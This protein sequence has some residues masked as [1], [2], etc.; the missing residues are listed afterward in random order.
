MF[1]L[2]PAELIG[3]EFL[4]S[5]VASAEHLNEA[6]PQDRDASLDVMPTDQLLRL[7]ES[8]AYDF[9]NPHLKQGYRTVGVSLSFRHFAPAPSGHLVTAT[10]R[11]D[12]IEGPKCL[13]EFRV[14]DEVETVCTGTYANYIVDIGWF[15][16]AVAGKQARR[17]GFKCAAS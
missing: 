12:V 4:R 15:R 16:N 1:I 17:V 8:S 7:I 5:T 3:R 13:F 6:R 10:L 2:N 9:I 14:V 11:L